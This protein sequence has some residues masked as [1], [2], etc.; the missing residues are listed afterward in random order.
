MDFKSNWDD[1][2][3]LIEFSYNKNYHS[4]IQMALMKF[5]MEEGVDLILVGLML[6]KPSC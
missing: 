4:S 1:H 5:F 3:S 2:L 6:V